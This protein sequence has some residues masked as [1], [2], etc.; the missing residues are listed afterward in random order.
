MNPVITQ[1]KMPSFGTNKTSKLNRDRVIWHF[2]GIFS[3]SESDL[4]M[5]SHFK[6]A[7]HCVIIKTVN[8]PQET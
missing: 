6:V 5:F 2:P 1:I 8:T 7:F 3:L 4:F